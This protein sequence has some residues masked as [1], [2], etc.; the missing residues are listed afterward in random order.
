MLDIVIPSKKEDIALLTAQ[1]QLCS[2]S[3]KLIIPVKFT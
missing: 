3:F 2:F 1:F